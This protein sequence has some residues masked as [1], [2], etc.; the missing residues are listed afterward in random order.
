MK[1]MDKKF[2][3]MTEEDLALTEGGFVVTTSTAIAWGRLGVASYMYGRYLGS[4]R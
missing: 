1:E 2:N 4:R 3:I